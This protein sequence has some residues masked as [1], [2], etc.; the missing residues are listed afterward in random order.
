VRGDFRRADASRGRFRDYV[1]TAL[2]HLVINHKRKQASRPAAAEQLAEVADAAE[3]SDPDAEFL[4]G[5]RKALLDRAWAALAAQPRPGAPPFHAVLRL[6]TEQPELSSQELLERLNTQLAPTPPLT[7]AGMR[8]ILQRAR[9]QFTDLL[10]EEVAR[11][12]GAPS[13]DEL[14]QEIID[15][16][17]QA[18]CRRALER[19]RGPRA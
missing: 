2:I 15:L 12:L 6:R 1:K 7:S 18:Y 5:W 9:E 11:S 14:E 17:F 16:G 10:V 4:A 13:P 3:P 19:R 8:K